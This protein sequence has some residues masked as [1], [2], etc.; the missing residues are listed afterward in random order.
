MCPIHGNITDHVELNAKTFAQ[1]HIGR[2]KLDGCKAD[3]RQMTVWTI[4]NLIAYQIQLNAH[5]SSTNAVFS[6]SSLPSKAWTFYWWAAPIRRIQWQFQLQT[7]IAIAHYCPSA[8]WPNNSDELNWTH[9]TASIL[10]MALVNIFYSTFTWLSFNSFSTT[11]F[12]IDSSNFIRHILSLSFSH[13]RNQ[14][15]NC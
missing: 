11:L 4:R 15:I 8:S 12:F 13:A 2:V 5:Y 7:I 3:Y 6:Q 9:S 10:T 14:G 1:W